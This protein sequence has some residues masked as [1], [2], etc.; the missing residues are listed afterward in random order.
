MIDYTPLFERAQ[1]EDTYGLG[2][3]VQTNNTHALQ[4][5][6]YRWLEDHPQYRDIMICI[7]SLP[8]LLFLVKK[9]VELPP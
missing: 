1:T 3:I 4:V 6:L 9:S 7:P 8:G 5:D 2:L